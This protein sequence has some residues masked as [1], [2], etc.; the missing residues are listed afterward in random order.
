MEIGI[1]QMV[2]LAGAGVSCISTVL[3]GS[4]VFFIKRMLTDFER[5]DRKNSAQIDKLE[6]RFNDLKSDL[7]LLYVTREDF[8]RTLNN[9]ERKIDQ[10]IAKLGF[11]TKGE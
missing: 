5:A 8:I 9:I 1:T 11:Y 2:A 10:L 7:P 3:V 4:L 6:E